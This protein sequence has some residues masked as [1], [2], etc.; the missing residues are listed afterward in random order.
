MSPPVRDSARL[1][2]ETL[3]LDSKLRQCTVPL[4]SLPSP[5]PAPSTAFVYPSL[6]CVSWA[7]V[8]GELKDFSFICLSRQS[9]PLQNLKVSGVG[10]RGRVAAG[11]DADDRER[12]ERTQRSSGL[13]GCGSCSGQSTALSLSSCVALTCPHSLPPFCCFPFIHSLP[14]FLPSFWDMAYRPRDENL[15]PLHHSVL[16]VFT[17]CSQSG[18]LDSTHLSF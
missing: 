9:L 2:L 12:G 1:P 3:P 15:A 5:R 16:H 18:S 4:L 14:S 6:A 13:T 11:C 10:R 7:G 17:L 8:W